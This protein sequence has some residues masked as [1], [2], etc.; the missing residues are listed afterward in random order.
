MKI[1]ATKDG[2]YEKSSGYV[3]AMCETICLAIIIKY[4]RVSKIGLFF[5]FL[6]RILLSQCLKIIINK[7]DMC[8]SL[9]S[10]LKFRFHRI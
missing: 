3:K 2:L 1:L 8:R 5:S 10:K 6:I 9:Q 4:T 7:N